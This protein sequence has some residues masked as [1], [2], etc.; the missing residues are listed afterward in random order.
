MPPETLEAAPD[1]LGATTLIGCVINKSLDFKTFV[2]GGPDSKQTTR[3][4]HQRRSRKNC[5]QARNK[6]GQF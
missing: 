1:L 3:T 6:D 5:G 2:G 4:Q